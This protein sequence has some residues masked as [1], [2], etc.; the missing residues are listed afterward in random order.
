VSKI[1]NTRNSFLLPLLPLAPDVSLLVGLPA[2]SSRR[3]RS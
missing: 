1:L 2:S 3:V